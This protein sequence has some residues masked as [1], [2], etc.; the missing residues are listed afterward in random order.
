M[1][2]NELLTCQLDNDVLQVKCYEHAGKITV[3]CFCIEG[4]GPDGEIS[5]SETIT[6]SGKSEIESYVKEVVTPLFEKKFGDSLPD[7]GKAKIEVTIYKMVLS[8]DGA[9]ISSLKDFIIAIMF[10]LLPLWT[11]SNPDSGYTYNF[12]V[13]GEGV[14][15]VERIAN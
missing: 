7:I 13:Y 14:W 4:F 1:N 11:L 9:I 5:L 6:F 15:I 10:L 3:S 8:K 12:R 2:P